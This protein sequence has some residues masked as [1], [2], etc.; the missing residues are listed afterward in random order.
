MKRGVALYDGK[1]KQRSWNSVKLHVTIDFL[2]Q[3]FTT[4]TK[5]I[6]SFILEVTE[7]GAET[8][9]TTVK[10]EVALSRKRHMLGTKFLCFRVAKFMEHSE[11][12]M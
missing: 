4:H 9:M 7:L 11:D 2:N 1:S 6:S 5:R 12:A 8:E 10:P 3:W